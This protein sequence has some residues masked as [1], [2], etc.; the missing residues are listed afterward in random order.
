[1]PD[2]LSPV[3]Q[4]KAS[5]S[6]AT[7]LFT[8]YASTFNGPVDSYGDIIAS[9]A[10]SSS[11]A[12]HRANGTVPALLW[13]HDHNEPIGKW[14]EMTEDSR[15]LVAT[16]KLTLGTKRG[17][18]AYQLMKDGAL[19]LSIGFAIPKGG[20]RFEGDNRI[21]TNIKLYEVSAVAMPA[22]PAATITAV[23]SALSETQPKTIREFEALLR[24]QL[25]FSRRDAAALATRGWAGLAEREAEEDAIDEVLATIK[26]ATAQLKGN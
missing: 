14:L 5:N 24:E 15:G 3:F 12:E 19:G 20:Q 16:G 11:L 2:R 17:S 25:G 7:G 8:G 21:L 9:G 26:R 6:D 18:E 13:A 23:K 22:N 1:M 10:F 4:F